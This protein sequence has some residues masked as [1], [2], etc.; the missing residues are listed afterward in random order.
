MASSAITKAKQELIRLNDKRKAME[1]RRKQESKTVTQGASVLVGAAAAALVD[2][3][4]GD[5]GAPA[6]VKGIPT[7]AIVGGALV[8]G[9]ALVKSLPF[10]GELA[11]AGLGMASAALYNLVRENVNFDS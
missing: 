10:R 6:E 1:S 8:A 7:N 3:K 11:G 5:G 4:F 9:S 2:E